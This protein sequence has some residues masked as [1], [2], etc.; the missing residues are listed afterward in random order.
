MADLG[1]LTADLRAL[2]EAKELKLEEALE[3][4]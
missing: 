4:N 1:A 3:L 2:V